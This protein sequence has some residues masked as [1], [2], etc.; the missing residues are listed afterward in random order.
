MIFDRQQEVLR[1]RRTCRR[2]ASP[3]WSQQFLKEKGVHPLQAVESF[4]GL[5]NGNAR[6]ERVN[7]QGTAL[8]DIW[9]IDQHLS[10]FL[11]HY[12]V[13]RV[14]ATLHLLTIPTT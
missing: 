6:H 7:G 8:Q 3:C 10:V 9:C 14:V 4:A 13:E 12:G 1:A 5:H 11:T 2:K